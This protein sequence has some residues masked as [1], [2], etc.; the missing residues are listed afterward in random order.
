MALKPSRDLVT[1]SIGSHFRTLAVPA[2][3]GMLFNTLYNIVDIF[4]A[5]LLSTDAQAGLAIGHL[6][7]DRSRIRT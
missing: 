1:G 6:R 4:F 3:I 5:G 7:P 2:A